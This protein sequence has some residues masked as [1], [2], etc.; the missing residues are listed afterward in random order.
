MVAG[1]GLVLRPPACESTGRGRIFAEAGD[2]C[3]GHAART[4]AMNDLVRSI[5]KRHVALR[6]LRRFHP[7]VDVRVAEWLLRVDVRDAIIGR[8][9]YLN[10]GY[11]G[12]TERLIRAI[13]LE[14]GVSV[15]IGANIGL[16][17][18]LMS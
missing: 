3:D 4:E 13:D 18:V 2:C 5:W 17:T 16:H 1:G 6:F 15:D 10:G 7:Q 11:E 9:L 8:L 14:G 12:E